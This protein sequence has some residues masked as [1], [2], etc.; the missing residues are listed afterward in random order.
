MWCVH[1]HPSISRYTCTC[2][3][4]Y[5]D[6]SSWFLGVVGAVHPCHVVLSTHLVPPVSHRKKLPSYRSITCCDATQLCT[7]RLIGNYE[8]QRVPRL[9]MINRIII[10]ELNALG[11]T[12]RSM[13]SYAV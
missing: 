13:C 3:K 1:L 9:T 6:N 11:D 12:M 2:M 5:Q 8:W 10:A 7:L 4:A